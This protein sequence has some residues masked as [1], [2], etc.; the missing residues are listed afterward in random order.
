MSD[1][2]PEPDAA[3]AV[4]TPKTSD[5][6]TS[7]GQWKQNKVHLITLPSGSKVKISLPDLPNLVRTG[8]IPNKLIDVA[9]SVANGEAR[10]TREAMEEQS[11]FYNALTAITV[12]EPKIT[13]EQVAAG[14]IPIEDK[15]VIVEFATRQRDMDAV[16]HHIGGLETQESFRRFRSI[17]PV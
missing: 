5:G 11:E 13:E 8:G 6:V 12:V 10:V 7:L 3:P 15:D 17:G 16:G 1:V 2:T 9:L 4:T 14:D